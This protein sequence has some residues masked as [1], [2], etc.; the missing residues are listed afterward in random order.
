MAINWDDVQKEMGGEFKDYAENGVFKVKLAEVNIHEIPS[1]SVAQDFIFEEG[2]DYKFPKVTHWLSFKNDNWRVWHN[3]NLMEVL[4]A[5][6]EQAKKAVEICESKKDKDA[7][8]QAYQSAYGKL[9][10]KNPE[11]EI[12]VWKED[13]SKYSD[14]DFTDRRVRMNRPEDNN[15]GNS[16]LK[17]GEEINLGDDLPF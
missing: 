14:A 8:V 5:S 10:S 15:K 1:G 6:D 7:I 13:G 2:D 3:K 11:V 17:S 12:E 16:V 9:A 4:G